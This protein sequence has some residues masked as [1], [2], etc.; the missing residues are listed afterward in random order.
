MLDQPA[1]GK[2]ILSGDRNQNEASE[3]QDYFR[4][5][6]EGQDYSYFENKISGHKSRSFLPRDAL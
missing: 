2:L 5:K 1:S 4:S 3:V 6:T